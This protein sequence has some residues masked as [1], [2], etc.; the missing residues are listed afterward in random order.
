MCLPFC[1]FCTDVYTFLVQKLLCRKTI[2]FYC[3]SVAVN[4]IPCCERTFA[5]C[6][7][8]VTVTRGLTVFCDESCSSKNVFLKNLK[9]SLDHHA[10][11]N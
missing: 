10:I 3:F 2:F 6:F 4:F 7:Q 1:T 8:S 5:H 11:K 9:S